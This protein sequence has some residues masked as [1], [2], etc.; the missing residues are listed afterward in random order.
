MAC[1]KCASNKSTS[2]SC[3]STSYT[4]PANAVYGDSTCYHP[5]ET[6]ESVTCTECVRHCH[7]ED[8]WCTDL[9]LFDY[10][11][12]SPDGQSNWDLTEGPTPV[13]FCVHKGERLDQ[14]LQKLTLA[15]SDPT[16]YPYK[17]KNFYV[18]TVVGGS[19]PSIT[20]VWFEFINS[21]IGISMSYKLVSADDWTVVTQFNQIV[22]PLTANTATIT[23]NML[24]ISSGNTYMFKLVTTW[25]SDGFTLQ[26]A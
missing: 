18:D 23:S 17:V 24:D 6:C 14:I 5:T 1:Q 19:T 22:N 7:G 21:L 8:K 12:Q 3:H 15:Q 25:Q 20:F 10:G 13:E 9:F 4:I 26:T 2:C 16:A 11:A